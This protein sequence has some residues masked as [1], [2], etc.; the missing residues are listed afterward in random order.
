VPEPFLDWEGLEGFPVPPDF[1]QER[2]VLA[3]LY[4]YCDESGKYKEHPIV[5]FSGLVD[6]M[7][8]WRAFTNRWV[9]LLR[10]YEIPTLHAVRAL[11]Y[12]QPLGKFGKCGTAEERA[13]QIAPFINEIVSGLALA[14]SVS[15]DVRAYEKTKAIHELYG[16]DPHYFACF[17]AISNM[18]TFF[19]IP[20]PYTIGLICDDEEQKAMRCYQLLNKL[21]R[22]IPE[23]RQRITSICFSDDRGAPQ[24]QTAD[25]FAYLSRLEAQRI[26]AERPYPYQSLFQSFGRVSPTGQHLCMNA[27]FF[28][29]SALKAHVEGSRETIV[30]ASRV[31][32]PGGIKKG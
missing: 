19:A 10:L 15:V 4:A 22:N 30:F 29:E 20:K 16:D 7:E 14:I 28:S 9:A 31:K 18:L 23:V 5:T 21:K 25:L 6:G 32:L 13:S 8:R 24:V 17:M 12:S 3:Y 2:S 27:Q 1:L 11:R 26:F